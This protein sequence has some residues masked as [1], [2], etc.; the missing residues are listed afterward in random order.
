MYDLI[1]RR[2]ELTLARKREKKVGSAFSRFGSAFSRFWGL[3][4]CLVGGVFRAV[5]LF[6]S[7]EARIVF[8][9]V[10][11]FL[12]QFFRNGAEQNGGLPP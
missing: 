2:G 12:N 4:S 7:S 11:F 3:F 6:I 9:S 10:L 1:S 8:S 5:L